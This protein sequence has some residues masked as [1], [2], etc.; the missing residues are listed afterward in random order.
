[1]VKG[2]TAGG[3][4]E[5]FA[6]TPWTTESAE[7]QAVDQRLPAEHLARRVARAV[8]MLDLTPLVDSYLGVG[9]KPLRPDLLLR[10]VLYELHNNRPS[11][12]IGRAH[13]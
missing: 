12:E 5:G 4:L 13:V 7:W 6:P 2:V 1:M 9:K 3:K 8:E 11:P 10:L